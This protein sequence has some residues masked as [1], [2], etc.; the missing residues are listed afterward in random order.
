[1]GGKEPA[2]D[3]VAVDGAL[4]ALPAHD[5]RKGRVVELLLFGGLIMEGTVRV[6][7]VSPEAVLRDWRLAKRWLARALP[8][9]K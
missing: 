6:L 2:C 3:L 5:A 4:E 1:M 8:G 7:R 9:G